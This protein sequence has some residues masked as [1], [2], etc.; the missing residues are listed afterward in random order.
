MVPSQKNRAKYCS[1][2]CFGKSKKGRTLENLGHKENCHCCV[3][4]AKRK[5]PL[6]HKKG[7]KCFICSREKQVGEN[8]PSWVKK[9]IVECR[10]CKK[11]MEITRKRGQRKHRV[12]CS[13]KCWHKYRN[14]NLLL[15]G[16]EN[17]KWK[18]KIKII[19]SYCKK[20]FETCPYNRKKK[21]CSKKC[22]SLAQIKYYTREKSSNWQGGKSFEPYPLGWTKTFKEQIRHRDG[23][24]CQI[25]GAPEMECNTKLHVHHKDYIKENI[26]PNNLISL[27]NKCHTRTNGNREY[28]TNYFKAKSMLGINQ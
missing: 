9:I 11:T 15:K 27:C 3:C 23:Y 4:R 16:S 7:C 25:C 19:C 5:E 14:K 21:F 20:E 10:E 18:E 22:Y 6:N 12:F 2:I 8:H 13:R 1:L 28:W 24:K 26:K 17:P